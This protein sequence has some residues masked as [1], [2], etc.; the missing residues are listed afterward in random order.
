M[1]LIGAS[2]KTFSILLCLILKLWAEV[3][4]DFE[5]R[6]TELIRAALFTFTVSKETTHNSKL[7]LKL[8]CS[9]SFVSA[10]V[11]R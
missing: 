8:L 7:R 11:A 3:K 1:K 6:T 2:H 4:S 5:R 10:G 9:I